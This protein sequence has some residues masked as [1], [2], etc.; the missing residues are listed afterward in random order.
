MPTRHEEEEE[1]EE[2]EERQYDAGGPCATLLS[3][4]TACGGAR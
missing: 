1:E 4:A 2:K 3:T